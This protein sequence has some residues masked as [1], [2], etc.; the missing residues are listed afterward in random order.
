LVAFCLAW[1]WTT[2]FLI[3]ASGVAAITGI[4]LKNRTQIHFQVLHTINL[5]LKTQLM[6][7]SPDIFPDNY[8]FTQSHSRKKNSLCNPSP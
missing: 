5:S 8:Q 6:W 7:V 3:S 4:F 2:I 1:P